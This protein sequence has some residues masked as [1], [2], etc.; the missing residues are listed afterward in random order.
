M[1]KPTP[2]SPISD[3]ERALIT[4]VI[5]AGGEGRRMGGEDKGLIQ[6][7][8]RRMVEQVLS[9]IVPQVGRVIINANRNRAVYAR[10]GHPVFSDEL[11]DFQGPL[12]GVATA[13]A[14]IDTPLL[15]TLPC[16][17]PAPPADLAERLYRSLQERKADIAMAHDGR[18]THPV[19]ALLRRELLPSLRDYLAAGDRKIDLWFERHRCITVDF[20]DEADAFLNVNSPE[21][22]AELER[23]LQQ[24]DAVAP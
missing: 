23:H 11:N 5:L 9:R 14:Q 12:A 1:H 4:A 22:R 6:L 3:D 15:L 2:V 7:A 18:R 10:L 16:D 24:S 8:G 21:D 17:S 19:F 20:S 13:L